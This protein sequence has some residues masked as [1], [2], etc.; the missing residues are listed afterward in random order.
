M[1]KILLSI[2]YNNNV[3][4]LVNPKDNKYK[5]FRTDDNQQWRKIQSRLIRVCCEI[6][7][8]NELKI[9]NNTNTS[10]YFKKSIETMMSGRSNTYKNTAISFDDI[11]T[12]DTYFIEEDDNEEK[13]RCSEM[14]VFA[15]I[16]AL[17]HDCLPSELIDC[18]FMSKFNF[19]QKRYFESR[20][21]NGYLLSIIERYNNDYDNDD[22]DD[23]NDDNNDVNDDDDSNLNNDGD[24]DDD[25]DDVVIMYEIED[26]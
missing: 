21:N 14:Q 2:T 13:D 15:M 8:F 6:G 16:K 22:N 26:V 5:D 25:D 18:S 9:F 4:V 12:D 11:V 7:T 3:H 17:E 19:F 23:D 1:K 20:I 24:D 10:Q